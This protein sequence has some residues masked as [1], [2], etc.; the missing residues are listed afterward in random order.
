[1][2]EVGSQELEYRHGPAQPV[3]IR[4]PGPKDLAHAELRFREVGQYGRILREAAN[5]PWAWFRLLQNAT[6]DDNG[7]TR[8]ITF[9]VSGRST[10]FEIWP[11]REMAP[12]T[13]SELPK[14]HFDPKL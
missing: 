8:R 7:G 14:V 2:L 5:G 3:T 9:T 13:L 4:W 6:F 11:E 10:T 12:L 1:V